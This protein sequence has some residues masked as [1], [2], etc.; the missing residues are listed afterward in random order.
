MFGIRGNFFV[1]IALFG[2]IPFVIGL[3]SFLTPRKAVVWSFLVAWLFLPMSD[4]PIHGFTDYN[5]MSAACVGVLIA[6]FFFDLDSLLA[7]RPKIWDIPMLVW[8]FCPYFSSI[9]NGFGAYDGLSSVAY[10]T[11]TWGLPYLIGR[12]YF[13]DLKGLRELAIGIVIG[14]LLYVP[15]CWFEI[16]MS[17][18]LHMRVYEI[19]RAHV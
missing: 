2:Y 19:G 1:V 6:A 5:K 15:L 4:L 14:G 16:R 7:F 17:P 11:T 12:L 9:Y 10:Q 3:F 13:Y 18:Q 8:C